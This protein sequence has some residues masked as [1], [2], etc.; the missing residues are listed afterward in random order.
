MKQAILALCIFG[1]VA[2]KVC[3][4]TLPEQ[5]TSID[6][7]FDAQAKVIADET[8]LIGE[9]L[10]EVATSLR[11]DT[12]LNVEGEEYFLRAFWNS[13]KEALKNATQKFKESA[14]NALKGALKEAVNE[15]KDH[16]KEAAKVAARKASDKVTEILS[17]LFSD[18][19]QGYALSEY[20]TQADFVKAVCSRID[21]V[22]LRLIEQGK[23]W[24]GRQ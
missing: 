13:T 21:S 20:E 24:A 17:K 23:N 11:Q 3:A 9:L 12:L 7:E 4:H 18:A 2:T 6:A 19:L 14:K 16:I 5:E 8:I 22:G 10:H 1:F 15:A